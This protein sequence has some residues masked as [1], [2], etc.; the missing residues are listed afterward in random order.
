[1]S[2]S[3]AISGP[4]GTPYTLAYALQPASIPLPPF[5]LLQLDPS[6]LRVVGTG[7]LDGDG[8]GEFGVPVPA[9]P[10]LVGASVFWQ[11][12]VGAPPILTN[13]ERTTIGS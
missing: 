9:S 4:A 10:I 7:T 5:G 11:G 13:A 8:D 2:D 12:L 1:M 3:W 6:T